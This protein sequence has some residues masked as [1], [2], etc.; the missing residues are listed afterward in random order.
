MR[1]RFFRYKSEFLNE[2][3]DI[4]KKIDDS[5]KIVKKLGFDKKI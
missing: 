2:N 3:F 1:F 4:S 5:N